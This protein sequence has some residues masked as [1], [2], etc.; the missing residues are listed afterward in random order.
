M[1][2]PLFYSLLFLLSVYLAAA[3]LR[4]PVRPDWE[5]QSGREIELLGET[6]EIYEPADGAQD[7]TSFTLS[8]IT[9]VSDSGTNLSGENTPSEVNSILKQKK[10]AVI[11]Y[12][13]DSKKQMPHMGSQVKIR[14]KIAPFPYAAN[15]GEFDAADYYG[16]KGYLFSLK[17]VEILEESREYDRVAERL[18]Q[19]AH[20]TDVLF[21]R[22]LGEEDGAIA[23]AMV[24]GI[25]KGMSADIKSLFGGAGISHILVVSGLHLSLIG[26][27][28]LFLL[29]KLRLGLL[30]S[31][32][33][34]AVILLL[35]G[36]MTGM[37]VSTRRAVL[38]FFLTLAAKLLKRTSDLP[39]SLAVAACVILLPEPELLGDAG[40]QLSFSAVAGAA[41][42]VPIMQAGEPRP[43][44]VKDERR[45]ALG[46]YLF[47]SL[48]A[49]FGITLTMLPV[50]LF[51]YYEWNPWSVAANLVVIP[52]M[53][54]LLPM[55]FFLAAAGALSGGGPGVLTVLKAAALP[56]KGIFLV[57][58]G[59]C[60][61][62]M[63]LP[64]SSLHTGIPEWWQL[65]IYMLGLAAFII[66]GK[67][68][69]PVIRLPLALLLTVIF[70][71]RLPGRLQITMLDVGQGECVC[72]ETPEHHIYIMDAGS[73]SKR[74]TGKYQ[75]VPFLKYTGVRSVQGI[76]I[77][78]W[79]EDHVNGL[80]DILSWAREG[81]VKIGRLYLPDTELEDDSLKK[82]ILLA[83]R[84]KLPVERLSAGQS[85]GDNRMKLTCMHPYEG[86]A[87]S[88][89]NQTSEVLKL[90]YGKFSALFMGDLES[91]GEAWLTETWSGE[92]LGCDLLYA[93]HHGSAN[94]SGDALLEKAS[95]QA[96]FISC[97][98]NNRYG[99]PAPEMI[100][101]LEERNLPFY[102]TAENGALMVSVHKKEMKIHTF[103][104]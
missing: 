98:R 16:M 65:A 102:V 71:I 96:V 79:D 19:T 18:L 25:K 45:A 7:K 75:I 39:T 13:A 82:L 49:S 51:C 47:Q 5:N 26:M 6:A 81:H 56:V 20:F 21:W 99:H 34:T 95:P 33:M 58:K 35:Y 74:K 92:A 101:R 9:S 46:R 23:S 91:E 69:R 85:M 41:V 40:L 2:R 11:C 76:F 80:E 54:L 63:R 93:G 36:Q 59:I 27:G 31:T 44:G 17:D 87:I 97:G 55:L 48:A 62:I 28:L 1:R 103:L 37:G 43:P 83:K 60:R 15:P 32:L 88:D 68:I 100:R 104:K 3:M 29:R 78:H 38:M 30:P 10:A 86:E 50:L 89:R 24:L 61:F 53:G 4:K 84:Y 8:H 14:G 73:T 42:M 77:S 66:W 94:A 57:Y 90:E 64:G 70:L 52:F 22:V 67:K 72:V 12:P